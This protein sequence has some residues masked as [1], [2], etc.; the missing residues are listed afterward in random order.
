MRVEVVEEVEELEE[1][2]E[3]EPDYTRDQDVIE[4]IREKEQG[5]KSG[6]QVNQVADFLSTKS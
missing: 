3:G 6:S 1:G 5:K 2:P 4:Y